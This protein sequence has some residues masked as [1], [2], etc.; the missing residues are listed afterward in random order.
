MPLRTITEAEIDIPEYAFHILLGNV[1]KNAF[2]YT[3]IG[4]VNVKVYCDKIEVLDT[5]KGVSI[6]TPKVEGYGLGLLLVRDICHRYGWY[7]DLI[8]RDKHGT[9]ATIYYQIPTSK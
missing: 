9:Y 1:I 2:A 3:Q 6:D 8:N 7:F 5:G 4:S